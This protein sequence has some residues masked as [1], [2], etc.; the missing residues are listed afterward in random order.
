MCPIRYRWSP[1]WLWNFTR[2]D[3]KAGFLRQIFVAFLLFS[4]LFT[5]LSG[6]MGGKNRQS[7][8]DDEQRSISEIAHLFKVSERKV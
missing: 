3:L 1:I 7:G 6:P 2:A 4:K 8:R 5:P